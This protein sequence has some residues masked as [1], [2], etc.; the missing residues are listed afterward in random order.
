L[1]GLVGVSRGSCVSN[2]GGDSHFCGILSS[3]SVKCWG[4]N[5][6]GRLGYGDTSDRGDEASEMGDYLSAVYL[7]TGLNVCQIDF[8][9]PWHPTDLHL[10]L[11]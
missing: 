7:G 9:C 3:Q 8:F 11:H 1:M 6:N 2:F 10:I 5:G 4:N